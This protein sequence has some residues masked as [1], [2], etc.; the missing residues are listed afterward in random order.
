MKNGDGDCYAWAKFFIDIFKVQGIQEENN[1]VTIGTVNPNE[2]FVI[3]H[4]T[5]PSLGNSRYP[6]Y[7]YMNLPALPVGT[8]WI[9][10]T[11]YNWRYEYVPY[12]SGVPGQG[13]P[14]PP[15]L[16][17]RHVVVSMNGQYY[18]PSY[19]LTYTNLQDFSDQMIIGYWTRSTNFPVNEVT[20]NL[21]LN[22]DGM[23]TNTNVLTEAILFRTNSTNLGIRIEKMETY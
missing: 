20:V 18:D 21:D 2:G 11:S 22:N 14:K 3:K 23:I 7:P 4:W 16:F 19:G 1:L 15:S 9:G 10:N 5:F 12:A 13:N 8:A 6:A 17:H